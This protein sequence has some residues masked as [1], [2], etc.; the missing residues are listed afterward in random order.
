MIVFLYFIVRFVTIRITLNSVHTV[1]HKM[2]IK[3]I[4]APINLFHD[5]A[6]VGQILIRF[7]RDVGV[8]ESIIR[9]VNSFIRRIFSLVSCPI[10]CFLYIINKLLY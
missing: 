8:I 2:I 1:H 3:F 5:V 6:P 10:L 7:I 4:K 9:V